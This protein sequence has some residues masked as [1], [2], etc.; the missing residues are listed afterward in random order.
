MMNEWR[1]M[2][3]A[4][5]FRPLPTTGAKVV[6]RVRTLVDRIRE[7]EHRRLAAFW[8]SSVGRRRLLLRGHA[9]A[10]VL[11]PAVEREVAPSAR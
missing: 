6:D 9:D 1:E 2:R 3:A 11:A 7:L 4:G 10:A 5:T 8:A